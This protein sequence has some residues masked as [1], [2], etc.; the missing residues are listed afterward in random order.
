MTPL[1]CVLGASVVVFV[2]LSCLSCPV[3]QSLYT[4]GPWYY[5]CSGSWCP[6]GSYLSSV[7]TPTSDRVCRP[8]A[9]GC[10]FCTGPL[11]SNCVTRIFA[12]V[13]AN[14]G[15]PLSSLSPTTAAAVP[16]NALPVT[17]AN[18]FPMSVYAT[19]RFT[20]AAPPSFVV[21][22]GVSPPASAGL[23]I[24]TIFPVVVSTVTGDPVPDIS[25]AVTADRVKVTVG[26]STPDAVVLP[27][28]MFLACGEVTTV[29]LAYNVTVWVESVVGVPLSLPSP[30]V[31]LAPVYV[32]LDVSAASLSPSS[33]TGVDYC[34]PSYTL[35]F[36]LSP[37]YIAA[38]ALRRTTTDPSKLSGPVVATLPTYISSDTP[39]RSL[40][41]TGFA[42]VFPLRTMAPASLTVTVAGQPAQ[43]ITL[44]GSGCSLMTSRP[45]RSSER[46][47]QFSRLRTLMFAS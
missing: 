28:Q 6:V 43:N 33:A 32:G 23:F 11:P 14:T 21:R 13:S 41:D 29:Q 2:L 4:S 42:V 35:S 9:A 15:V 34:V 1:P 39:E 3:R 40:A 10:T 44:S 5:P 36:V 37:R 22:F 25:T 19:L 24:N 17:C 16:P 8:C 20:G 30:P 47:P 46:R 45:D 26:S 12:N 31:V 38:S 7:C 18:V 27:L